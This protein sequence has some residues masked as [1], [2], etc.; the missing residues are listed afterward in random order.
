MKVLVISAHADDAEL[1]M[2]GT[3]AR[4]TAQGHNVKFLTLVI[5]HEDRW[6]HGCEERRMVRAKDH[7]LATQILGVKD[8]EIADMDPY[9]LTYD[10]YL[11][12][13]LD[14]R[15]LEFGPDL[16]FTHWTGDSHQ[17][18]K[19]VSEA[20]FSATRKNDCSVLMYHELVLGGITPHPFKPQIFV[21]ISA[22]VIDKRASLDCY[23]FIPEE[24]IEAIEALSRFNGSQINVKHAECFEAGKVILK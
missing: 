1:S 23:D 20:T 13:F 3:V 19:H 16:I 15:I 10:R 2:G 24:K 4:L 21:D 8:L 9:T 12:K 6:G 5:P 14:E 18:H 17:N 22:H 7:V 11:V